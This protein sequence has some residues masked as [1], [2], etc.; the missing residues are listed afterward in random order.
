MERLYERSENTP[1]YK[2]FVQ[3]ERG[4]KLPEDIPMYYTGEADWPLKR[5]EER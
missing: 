4:Q 1:Q 5:K 3:K 2:A